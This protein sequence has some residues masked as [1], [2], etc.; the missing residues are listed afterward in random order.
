M[1]DNY[2]V[3]RRVRRNPN[4]PIQNQ[5]NVAIVAHCTPTKRKRKNTNHL[6]QQRC[7]VCKEKKTSYVCNLCEIDKEKEIWLCHP[8][9]GRWCLAAHVEDNHH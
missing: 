9:T 3:E 4:A 5:Q 7:H 6:C 8:R 1:I 2:W